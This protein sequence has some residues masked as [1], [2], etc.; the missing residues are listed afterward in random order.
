MGPMLDLKGIIDIDS[1][2]LPKISKSKPS[3]I[4]QD[5]ETFRV[6]GSATFSYMTYT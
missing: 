3:A 2:G 4:D 6:V 1:S 5:E